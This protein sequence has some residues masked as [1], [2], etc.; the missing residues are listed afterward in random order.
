[1]IGKGRLKNGVTKGGVK[2]IWAVTTSGG[3]GCSMP[4][5]LLP[6]LKLVSCTPC[7]IPPAAFLLATQE[8]ETFLHGTPKSLFW[9]FTLFPHSPQPTLSY[10]LPSTL[11]LTL[12]LCHYT[13]SVC[14]K[15]FAAWL[16]RGL[17]LHLF[18]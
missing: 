5:H 2:W 11:S 15:H 3:R 17:T 12:T 16:Y 14:L 10:S 18:F 9:G 13:L 6:P 4:P 1:M 8:G 7:P